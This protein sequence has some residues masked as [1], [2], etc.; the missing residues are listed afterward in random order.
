MSTTFLAGKMSTPFLADEMFTN[1]LEIQNASQE[2]K[3]GTQ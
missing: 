2:N 1:I 3:S